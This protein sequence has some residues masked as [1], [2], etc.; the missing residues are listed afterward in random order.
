MGR[1]TVE[2]MGSSSN[3]TTVATAILV[4]SNNINNIMVVETINNN[5]SRTL[6]LKQLSKGISHASYA[7][8]KV[9]ASSCEA[10]ALILHIGLTL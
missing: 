1:A 6:R 8:W 9:A 4:S 5:N 10:E 2:T 3:N 7:S